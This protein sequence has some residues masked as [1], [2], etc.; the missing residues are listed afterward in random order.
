[1][2]KW[3]QYMFGAVLAGAVCMN[4]PQAAFAYDVPEMIEVGL[5]SVCKN[6]TS[7]SIGSSQLAVGTLKNDKFREDGTI[8]SSGGFTAKMVRGEV[9]RITDSMSQ[10]AAEDLAYSLRRTGFDASCGYLGNDDWTVYVQ[11]S[12][13]SEVESASKKSA[14]RISSF[15]GICLSGGGEN[16]LMV[17]NDVDYGFSGT[18]DTFTING[19]QYRGCLR[20]AVNGTV[21]TAVNVVDLEEYLYGVIP[22]EMP[23]SYGEEALKAQTLAARTYAMTKLN[24]H[25]SS[26][27][28]LCDTINCQVYKGYSGENSKTNAIVDETEGE[29]ICYNG[30]PIEAVFSASTGGYTENS[31]NVWNSVVPY[32]RAVPEVGEYGNNTWTKTLTLS[33]LDS[34]LSAKGENIGS[35]QD[36]VITKISTGG[37]VQE[38]KIVG[39]SGSVTLTKENIRT[40]FSGAC[41]SL[42][43]K[44][45][46]INGKGGDPSSGSRSVQ[47]QATKSSSTGSLTSSAA[48][49]GITAKTEGTLSAMNGKN[50]KLDGLSVSENTNSNQNTPVISTEDYQIYDVNISTVEN[51]TFVFEGS[52]NGHGVGLSQNGAQG[53]AQQGYSYEEIIKHYYTGVTIEG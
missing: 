9:I 8:S 26:G 40:Y 25:K 28:E 18:D 31:E 12:S 41:G 48:A 23:A 29:I 6:A 30:T 38:M 3:K 36:I 34:L 5:E 21:M 20:F 11:N 45:F 53:M 13:R 47:R 27:Y 2:I 1:M 50:L 39:T 43:S 52:G 51:G 19:K 22:A 10:K 33:Q 44:M 4:M 16:L 32:L 35:A 7:A 15:N 46:T 14:E 17:S 49:N 42:P 24:A 37:R